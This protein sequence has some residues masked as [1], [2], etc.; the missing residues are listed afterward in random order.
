MY[1]TGALAPRARLLD[2]FD[3]V[4]AIERLPETPSHSVG[5][6]V[7]GVALDVRPLCAQDAERGL[8]HQWSVARDM[9]GVP[10]ILGHDRTVA[11]DRMAAGDAQ[12][13]VEVLT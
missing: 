11:P 9:A 13:D 6:E 4:T 7:T 3:Q 8:E 10:A 2:L 1:G 5:L 12:V